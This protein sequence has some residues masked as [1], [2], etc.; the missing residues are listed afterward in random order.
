[1]FIVCIYKCCHCKKLQQTKYCTLSQELANYSPWAKSSWLYI[2]VDKIVL[3]KAMDICSFI[4]CACFL[5]ATAVLNTCNRDHME[6][7]APDVSF[8]VLWQ[9]YTRCNDRAS[10][11]RTPKT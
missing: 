9:S 1:M 5:A 3:D 2:F 8:L 7:K 6:C 11:S 10:E 4:I